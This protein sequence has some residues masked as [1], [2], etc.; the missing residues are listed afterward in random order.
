MN[1]SHRLTHQLLF[2][3]LKKKRERSED[4]PTTR[5]SRK[6]TNKKNT[7]QNA[8]VK[9]QVRAP[10]AAIGWPTSFRVVHGRKKIIRIKKRGW[11]KVAPIECETP[12]DRG[13]KP[14]TDTLTCT[15]AGSCFPT[16]AV[17]VLFVC[18]FFFTLFLVW[19]WLQTEKSRC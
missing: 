18:L 8:K 7:K 17:V 3:A 6:R 19:S 14:K 13:T 16:P 10:G 9:W 11:K 4:T 1:F 12:Q 5:K 2:V 15:K